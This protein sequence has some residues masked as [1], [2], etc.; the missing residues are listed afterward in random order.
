M[1]F[2]CVLDNCPVMQNS[3]T[4]FCYN[5]QPPMPKNTV[6]KLM[7]IYSQNNFVSCLSH[8]SRLMRNIFF[9]FWA[10]IYNPVQGQTI[11]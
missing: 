9:L 5:L 7:Q 2:K 10:V 11:K 6:L 4:V 8:K 3:F 1:Y